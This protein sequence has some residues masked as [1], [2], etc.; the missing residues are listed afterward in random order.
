MLSSRIQASPVESDQGEAI[1]AAFNEW[2]KTVEGRARKAELHS[3]GYGSSDHRA[4]I[5]HVHPAIAALERSIYG[6]D[7][8]P[9]FRR[10]QIVPQRPSVAKRIFLTAVYILIA[11]AIAG[12]ALA[13]RSSD[14]KI[15]DIVAA[16]ESSLN[17]FSSILGVRSPP[18]AN[19]LAAAP[20]SSVPD[21][22]PALNEAV[23]QAAPVPPFAPA[24]VPPRASHEVQQQLATIADDLAAMRQAM[25]QIAGKQ[26]Q[27]AQDIAA[28][29]AAQ[30]K[31]SQKISPPNLLTGSH[32]APRK[33]VAKPVRPEAAIEPAPV[34]VPA[35][36]P[37]PPADLP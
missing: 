16:W 34:P 4:E 3:N 28:L 2:A 12:A 24:P 32:V 26:D 36:R 31:I 19:V 17:H 15:K 33:T 7:R 23:P 8:P 37:Q 25:E 10:Q 14:D 30:Q 29:Q 21:Q 27:M 20:V 9:E 5:S 35:A 1:L 13:W 11:G 18:S 22:V 6:D